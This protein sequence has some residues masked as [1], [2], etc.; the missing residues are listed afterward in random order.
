[1]ES[2][3]ITITSE[4]RAISEPPATAKP[5]I[6]QT[7]GLRD[8]QRLIKS[9]AGT[10]DKLKRQGEE[11]KRRD[12]VKKWQRERG[13]KSWKAGEERKTEAGREERE[14]GEEGKQKSREEGESWDKK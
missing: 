8:L 3:A 9:S 12:T 5:L 10:R 1:L 2:S 13:K 4:H 11:G 6:L 14:V 7:T